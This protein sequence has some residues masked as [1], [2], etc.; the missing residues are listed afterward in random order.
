MKKISDL[1]K[2]EKVTLLH[3]VER[4]VIDKSS[5]TE[6]TT[7]IEKSEDLF[8]FMMGNVSNGQ[9]FI[10]LDDALRCYITMTL[11]LILKNLKDHKENLFEGVR[12][13]NILNLGSGIP[14]N[15]DEL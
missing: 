4:G 6:E 3:C 5:L 2:D 7:I 12:P 8:Y 11:E 13:Y 15:E 10:V 9:P 14:L 1:N